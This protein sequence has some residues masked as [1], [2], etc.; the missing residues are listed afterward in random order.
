MSTALATYCSAPSPG[1]A[2]GLDHGGMNES[3]QQA[4]GWVVADEWQLSVLV[5]ST[6][7]TGPLDVGWLARLH[8]G[9]LR[10]AAE[11]ERRERDA[12]RSV[13]LVVAPPELPDEGSSQAHEDL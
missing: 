11:I 9:I 10:A 5:P 13:R 7:S 8:R 6:R 1:V 2:G 3:E 4:G 12:G